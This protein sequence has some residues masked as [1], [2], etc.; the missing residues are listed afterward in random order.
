MSGGGREDLQGQ[1]DEG[2]RV[3]VGEDYVA[4]EGGED[5]FDAAFFRGWYMDLVRAV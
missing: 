1:L 4:E 2:V 5:L 3:V